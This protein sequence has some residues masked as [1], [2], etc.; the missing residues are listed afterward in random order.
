M[1]VVSELSTSGFFLPGTVSAELLS[2]IVENV[3]QPLFVKDRALRFVLLNRAFG[4]LVG[5]A[6]ADMLG[7]TDAELF[8]SAL[9]STFAS[10]ASRVFTTGSTEVIEEHELT[11]ASGE[12]RRVRTVAAPLHDADGSVTHLVGVI[13]DM[14]EVRAAEAKLRSA[15]EELERAV[16]ERTQALRDVQQALLRKERLTVLGQLAGGLAHQIRNPLAAMQTAAAVLR[17]RLGEHSDEDV[18][19]ALTVIREEV[20]EANRIITDLLD[21][22][23]VKPP[24]V[25]DVSVEKLLAAA[26]EAVTTPA[27]VVVQWELTPDLEVHVDERQTRDAIGNVMRNA[28][29]AMSSGGTLTI[30]A[31]PDGTDVMITIE[32]TGAGF[33][34]DTAQR[35]FEPLVT[36]K[37]LGLGLGLSTARA[38]VQNQGGTIRAGT[39]RGT[40]ARFELR[41]PMPAR[42]A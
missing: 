23:R 11:H 37:P 20:W 4:E 6:R 19:H 18:H 16:E 12:R 13:V 14:S 33:A 30:G 34:R 41:L 3:A 31:H 35:L 7:R 29:E 36:T 9:A 2:A 27:R 32:D 10:A 40:G 17:R 8:P 28:F 38:L 15:N 24:S 5:R 42:E 25:A 1:A 26:L 21:Y 39:P 22:A